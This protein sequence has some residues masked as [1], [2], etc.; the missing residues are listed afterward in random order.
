MF[1]DLVSNLILIL[2]DIFT[3]LKSCLLIFFLLVIFLNT[4]ILLSLRNLIYA[5]QVRGNLLMAINSLFLNSR[6][7]NWLIVLF[8]SNCIA[9]F[10]NGRILI[11]WLPLY[12]LFNKKT[13]STCSLAL[14]LFRT[15]FIRLI[16]S[17]HN[18]VIKKNYSKFLLRALIYFIGQFSWLIMIGNPYYL[19][20]LN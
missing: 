1:K 11:L 15:S 17:Y 6:R 12:N 18:Q 14:R 2:I 4:G 9:S 7:Y 5:F 10:L 20:Y 16:L 19:Y 13:Y 8:T 3:E